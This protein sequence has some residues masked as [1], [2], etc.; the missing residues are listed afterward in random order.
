MTEYNYIENTKMIQA[1]RGYTRRV[2]SV[3]GIFESD[4]KRAIDYLQANDPVRDEEHF[5]HGRLTARFMA[6]SNPVIR[7]YAQEILGQDQ[8]CSRGQVET[9]VAQK[10]ILHL[11]AG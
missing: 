10:S 11:V 5:L 9:G 7:E 2:A 8:G 1:L 4:A 6:H 3:G